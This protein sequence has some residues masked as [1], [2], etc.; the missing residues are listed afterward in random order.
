VDDDCLVCGPVEE[1]QCPCVRTTRR[2]L[3]GIQDHTA[4]LATAGLLPSRRGLDG[5]PS[6]RGY[7]SRPPTSL[8]VL[9]ALDYRSH[10]TGHG[11]DD[12]PDETTLSIL[13]SLHQ[14]AAH[15]AQQRYEAAFM[16]SVLPRPLT[17][18]GLANY[19]WVHT[20]W[21]VT[22]PWGAD[23]VEVVRTLH[24]QTRRQAGD[25]PPAPLGPCIEDGCT[26]VVWRGQL[27]D[28]RGRCS[29]NAGHVYVGLHLARLRAAQ[30]EG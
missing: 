10:T 22:Q 14:I 17:V 18:A 23:Y 11:P 12:D 21:C 13:R 19:L 25:R 16:G 5:L 27:D 1:P 7:A 24:A 28:D 4:I 29:A 8:D 26:G 20:E 2:R 30:Q 6:P 15:V 3:T 9:T